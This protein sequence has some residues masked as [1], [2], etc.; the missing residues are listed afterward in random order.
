MTIRGKRILITG[1]TG[2]I[3]RNLAEDMGSRGLE[4]VAV[5]RKEAD[6]TDLQAARSLLTTHE[7]AVL[8]HLAAM[9]GGIHANATR[10]AEFYE[11]NTLINTH[12]VLAAREAGVEVIHA[13]GTGCAYPKRLEAEVLHEGDFL[14]GIP[15]PTNDAYAYAKR[16]LL[17]HLESLSQQ[18]G[19]Q[20]TYIIPAN[21]YGPQDNFHPRWSHVVPGLIVRFLKAALQSAPDVEIWGTG[22]V[23]RDFLYI[24]DCTDAIITIM[25]SEELGVFNVSSGRRYRVG[26]LAAI[27]AV[28]TGFEGRVVYNTAYPDGQRTRVMSTA[29]MD[30]LG[31]RP[32]CSLREG[33]RR[34]VQWCRENPDRWMTLGS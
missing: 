9:V 18:Y 12:A 30:E 15:E 14:D 33:I 24:A 34:T 32:K 27:I 28:E 13:M 2:L 17:V 31:W 3:G 22:K 25:E 29:R 10:K 1:G 11:I 8:V 19:L 5:G 6:L 23:E 20:Y 4:V 26:E 21:I 16:N 7:P